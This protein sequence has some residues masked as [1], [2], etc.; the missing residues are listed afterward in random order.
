V[1]GHWKVIRSVVLPHAVQRTT[2]RVR[3]GGAATISGWVGTIDGNALGAQPVRILT[4][5][6]NGSQQFTQAAVATTAPDG[7]WSAQLPTGPS[8]LVIASYDGSSTVE[9]ASS[10]PVRVVVP[11]SVALH[12]SST[13]ARW[14][15]R[16]RITGQVQGGYVPPS[17][18]LVVLWIGWRGGST[19]IGHLY[20][21]ADGS[22][23]STY[24]FLRGTGTEAYRL[25]AA[26]V[27]ESDYPYAPGRSRSVAVTVRP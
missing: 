23:G 26:T 25:W 15:G 12:L 20:T 2:V 3:R 6:D 16:I 14:G 11:A 10:A 13:R 7:T 18:E 21:R 9:P 4:A 1:H 22:F 17:G 27:R 5:P 19:E 8:R 24:T